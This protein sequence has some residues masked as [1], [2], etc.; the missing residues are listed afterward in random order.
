MTKVFLVTGGAGF[1]GAHVARRLLEAGHRVV[2]A[3]N[4]LT[5]YRENVPEEAEFVEMDLADETQYSRLDAFR[6]DAVLHL[7]GQSSGEIS[8]DAPLADLAI[9]TRATILLA[10]W[11]QKRR[12]RRFLYTSTVSIY[13][14][15]L[16]E[17]NMREGDLPAPKSFYA[18]SKLASENYLKVFDRAGEMDITVFRVFNAYGPGQNMANMKQGMVSIYLAYLIYR[19]R[20]EI[21]GSLDRF[22]DFIYITDIVDFVV[23]CIEDRRAYGEVFNLGTG[24]R[25]R[26]RELVDLLKEVTGKTDFPVVEIEGTPGDAFGTCADMSYVRQKLGW[27]PKVTLRQGLEKMV[28]FYMHGGE[29]RD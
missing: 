11:A 4:L 18:C 14:E 24:I 1:I 19:E 7:A 25:V 22:R 27:S 5:G 10:D 6:P 2:V 20:L 3:D 29:R 21:K 15:A 12:C 8:H 16:T 13:G 23:H 17:E 26:V 9:N 28:A